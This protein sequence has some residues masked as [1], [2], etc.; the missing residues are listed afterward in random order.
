MTNEMKKFGRMLM[1]G[2]PQALALIPETGFDGPFRGGQD[3]Q[4]EHAGLPFPKRF[5]ASGIVVPV[6]QNGIEKKADGLSAFMVHVTTGCVIAQDWISLL[7][8]NEALGGEPLKIPT[9]QPF[10]VRI[11]PVK[12][13]VEFGM[14]IHLSLCGIMWRE[15]L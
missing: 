6:I 13:I 7:H 8:Y 1:Q 3:S 5:A 11:K 15:I 2:V 10:I 14:T 4:F 9:H 12:D